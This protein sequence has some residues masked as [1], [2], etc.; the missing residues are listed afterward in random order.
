MQ[1]IRVY[2]RRASVIII[3][4]VLLLV[5]QSAT[6]PALV[7]ADTTLDQIVADLGITN[8]AQMNLLGEDFGQ[9]SDQLNCEKDFLELVTSKKLTKDVFVSC[10]G[11]I[12][13][14]VKILA[15]YIQQQ[16][17][18]TLPGLFLPFPLGPDPAA[19]IISGIYATD[20][21]QSLLQLVDSAASVT[22]CTTYVAALSETALL[23][24]T[25]ILALT[26]GSLSGQLYIGLALACGDV[27][28]SILTLIAPIAIFFHPTV[29][30]SATLTTPSLAPTA[31]QYC[32]GANLSS[33][34]CA[35][36]NTPSSST[37]PATTPPPAPTCSP[38]TN[39]AALF[40]G[41]NF[42]GQCVVL[43]GGVYNDP[44]SMNIP[45]DS[46]S[47][48]KVGGSVQLELCRDNGLSNTCQWFSADKGDL[49][50]TSVGALQA[51]SAQVVDLSQY[52][53][54]C[55]STQL[56]GVCKSFGP[57]T[58]P[59]LSVYGL[60][61]NIVSIHVSS[62]VTLYLNDGVNLSGQPGIFNNDIM[63]L[64][65]NGWNSRAK[66]LKIE[67]RYDTSCNNDQA[68]NGIL[69]YRNTN[70]DTGGCVLLTADNND[71]GRTLNFAN[72]TS[73]QFVGNYINH[74]QAT[75]YVDA[76]YGTA[77]GTYTV[78]QS[79]L[80][81]CAGK[82]ASIKIQPYTPPALANNVAP[83]A[84]GATLW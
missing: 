10:H 45:N 79:D 31:K 74:Y 6:F 56:R 62:V 76:N 2:V 64:T 29:L 15:P 80:L 58:V 20:L 63:D 75:I 52:V 23:N 4:C 55:T 83:Y 67:N 72:G 25:I 34:A 8:T 40:T 77:C 5:G 16:Q 1:R 65:P 48:V 81:G 82:T 59:D 78:N 26:N 14:I 28:S 57:G 47:S 70:F 69:L 53:T 49:S 27:T 41:K 21:G 36:Q 61:S 38:A 18:I 71:L 43:N 22:A 35:P 24:P 7:H 50:T 46:V 84:A 37:P 68:Q 12:S 42:T 33:I 66:S 44:A 9:A 17:N 73:L 60:S 3:S 32:P 13:P 54:V 30:G 19:V 51:S 39:Q 11:Q